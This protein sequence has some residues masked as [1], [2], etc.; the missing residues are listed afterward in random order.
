MTLTGKK[1]F[2][3]LAQRNGFREDLVDGKM[4]Y[5]TRTDRGEAVIGPVRHRRL[6]RKK[7]AEASGSRL[8][9]PEEMALANSARIINAQ[10]S[11]MAEGLRR[12]GFIPP[13]PPPRSLAGRMRDWAH[14]DEWHKASR[15]V[16][17]D[18][19]MWTVTIT[20]VVAC[21]KA[22]LWLL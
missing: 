11:E 16:A 1:L 2:R 20:M 13:A 8:M 21:G 3:T 15:N 18:I 22:L 10:F 14:D 5:I 6:W 7:K 9:T 4:H 12:S 17:A 19:L